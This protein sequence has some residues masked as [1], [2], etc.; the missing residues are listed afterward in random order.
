M[1]TLDDQIGA[2]KVSIND[3]QHEVSNLLHQGDEYEAGEMN[4]RIRLLKA[5]INSLEA[6]KKLRELMQ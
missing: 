6:I 3:A 1:A 2:I 4:E 5:A